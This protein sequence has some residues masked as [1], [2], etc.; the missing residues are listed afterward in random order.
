MFLPTIVAYVNMW[1]DP[2]TSE[3]YGVAPPWLG[4]ARNLWGALLFLA[5]VFPVR[6]R[7]TKSAVT[8]VVCS[9]ATLAFLQTTSPVLDGEHILVYC[10]RYAAALVLCLSIVNSSLAFDRDFPL[11]MFHL[12]WLGVAGQIVMFYAFGLVPSHTFLEGR[13]R[14]SGPTNDSL[15]TALILPAFIPAV[16]THPARVVFSAILI[17]CALLSGSTYALV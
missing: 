10:L 15:A 12:F 16:V 4:P 5:L 14:F 11:F 13:L 7:V 8:P 3:G 9:L 6:L 17:A 2:R 1:G